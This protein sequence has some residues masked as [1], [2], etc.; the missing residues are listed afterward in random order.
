[1][2][3]IQKLVGERNVCLPEYPPHHSPRVIPHILAQED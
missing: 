3:D 1:M 2:A